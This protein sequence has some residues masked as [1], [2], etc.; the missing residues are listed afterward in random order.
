MGSFIDEDSLASSTF[1]FKSTIQM[2]LV[3]SVQSETSRHIAPMSTEDCSAVGSPHEVLEATPPCS[4]KDSEPEELEILE[5][6]TIRYEAGQIPVVRPSEQTALSE[7]EAN[8]IL[9]S[10]Q[11]LEPV[12]I[13]SFVDERY[14][15][16]CED[17]SDKDDMPDK[18]RRAIYNKDT[19]YKNLRD[20]VPLNPRILY[21]LMQCQK[22]MV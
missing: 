14:L 15:Q 12:K 9:A 22:N 13:Q 7:E 8:E 17:T 21:C 5:V 1:W 3:R 11:E 4:R 2:V 20:L 16:F 6:I 10:V 18:R 19:Y